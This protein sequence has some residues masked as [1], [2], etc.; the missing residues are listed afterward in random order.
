MS[1]VNLPT[2]SPNYIIVVSIPKNEFFDIPFHIY[3]I[4]DFRYPL[5]HTITGIYPNLYVEN[6]EAAKIL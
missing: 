4:P 1:E 5:D 6:K 3:Q 2:P